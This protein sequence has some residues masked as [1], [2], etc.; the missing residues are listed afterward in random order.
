MA[1][2]P[3]DSGALTGVREAQFYDE[4]A[5]RYDALVIV[6]FGGPEG[7]DDVEPF[8]DNVLRG[9]K[10]SRVAKA[11]IAKRYAQF[12]GVSPIAAHTRDLVAAVQDELS[13]RGLTLPVYLGNRNW[14]PVLP[15]TL[16]AME[17]DGVARAA[18]FV[19][20]TFGS[21]NG[22][23]RYREDL[24]EATKDLCSPPVIDRLR[25]G[26]NHPGFIQAF[27]DRVRA[28]LAEVP[29]GRRGRTPIL[30]TAHSLPESTARNAPYVP[31]LREAC[32]LVC[33][34]LGD[35]NS[36]RWRLVYQSNNARYG[37]ER[38]LGPDISEALVAEQ[39]CGA[40]D[41]VVAPIGFVCDHLEVTL[42][43]DQEARATA[44]RIGINFVRAETV[45]T[46]SAFVGMI[47]DLLQERL[48]EAPTRAALG[49][50]GPSHDLCPSNCCRSG[51]PSPAGPSIGGSALP[52]RR[53]FR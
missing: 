21:Y 4:S 3:S 30:F 6:S 32:R 34:A 13:A 11:R 29:A 40:R 42:D 43:L 52:G 46:H 18:A 2:V 47:A 1:G 53:W 31:Q 15:E 48:T 41:V 25:Y 50:L 27:T 51:R 9:L 49:R 19:T 39:D 16:T 37:G 20:C 22:C 17:A 14:H 23:R 36:R 44:D 26:Y 35:R 8:L 5:R 33:V 28:A 24:H 38:W 45:G 10:L 7:M 12:G